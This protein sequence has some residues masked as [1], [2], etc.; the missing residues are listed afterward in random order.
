MYTY[1]PTLR[2]ESPLPP[3]PGSLRFNYT[4]PKLYAG[5]TLG[6]IY[7]LLLYNILVKLYYVAQVAPCRKHFTFLL[8]FC[9]SILISLLGIHIRIYCIYT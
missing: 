8:L 7:L 2:G 4:F 9:P 1:M 3:P 6:V 5:S